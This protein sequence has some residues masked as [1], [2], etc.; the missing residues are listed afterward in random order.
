[1]LCVPVCVCFVYGLGS[2]EQIDRRKVKIGTE[3]RREAE[4][5]KGRERDGMREGEKQ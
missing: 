4:R 5:E 3:G 2:C 1:V